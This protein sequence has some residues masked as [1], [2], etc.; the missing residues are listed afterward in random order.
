MAYLL[1]RAA[2]RDTGERF[3]VLYLNRDVEADMARAAVNP[4]AVLSP[5][6]DADGAYHV[7]IAKNI[8]MCVT[9]SCPAEDEQQDE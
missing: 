2:A 3:G 7:S 8:I 4:T 5:A 6:Y 1:V 9:I